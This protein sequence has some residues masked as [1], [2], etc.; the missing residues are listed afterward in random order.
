MLIQN[1]CLKAY[2]IAVI[3]YNVADGIEGIATW[4]SDLMTGGNK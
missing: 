3:M 4:Q 2:C 1:S